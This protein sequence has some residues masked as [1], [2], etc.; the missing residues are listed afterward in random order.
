MDNTSL[1]ANGVVTKFALEVISK[2]REASTAIKQL[3]AS[4]NDLDD[5][6]RAELHAE[7]FRRL[8]ARLPS[9]A[10]EI[11]LEILQEQENKEKN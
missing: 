8:S 5:S 9:I 10:K 3:A 1:Q 11:V 7:V 2:L 6:S 4:T